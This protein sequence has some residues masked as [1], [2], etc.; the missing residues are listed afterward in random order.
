M[1]PVHWWAAIGLASFGAAFWLCKKSFDY[2]ISAR[3]LLA[4]RTEQMEMLREAIALSNYGARA[5]AAELIDRA[6]ELGEQK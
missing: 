2:E 5:E 6:V 3:D 1:D 4:R